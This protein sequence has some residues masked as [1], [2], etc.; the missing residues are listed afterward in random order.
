MQGAISVLAND[1]RI[2][3]LVVTGASIGITTND[4]ASGY[5]IRRNLV[6][7]NTRFGIELQSG[8]ARRT[9]VEANCLRNNGTVAGESGAIVSELGGLKNAVIRKNITADNFEGISV[10]GPH[11]HA[12]ISI[13]SN[14]LRREAG[15]IAVSGT[16][17]SDITGNDVDATGAANSFAGLIMGVGTLGLTIASNSVTGSFQGIFFDRSSFNDVNPGANV[18]VLVMRNH[19]HDNDGGGILSALPAPDA[20]GN[21]VKSLIYFNTTDRQAFSGISLAPGSDGNV[22]I[23]NTST[24]NGSSGIALRGA[25]GNL[26][27]DNTMKGNGVDAR[28]D[29]RDQNT[30]LANDCVTELTS[31]APICN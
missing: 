28:D 18:G 12:N 3:G 22:L 19:V 4:R 27:R 6:E 16:V 24:A 26:V 29:A 20:P 31:G 8:G 23:G 30:W 25:V 14:I 21:L 2:D 1:V 15:G 9:V 13:S 17:A 11:P 10:A 7:G 5:R